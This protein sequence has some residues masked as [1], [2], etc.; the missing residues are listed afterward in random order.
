MRRSVCEQ[1]LFVGIASGN[2][3]FPT[4]K[5]AGFSR[6]VEVYS[7]FGFCNLTT[8]QAFGVDPRQSHRRPVFATTYLWLTGYSL[9]QRFTAGRA[10]HITITI[11]RL[12]STHFSSPLEVELE[13]ERRTSEAE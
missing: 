2:G 9:P 13:E 5:R 6:V 1:A 12:S 8:G 3:R 7:V 11:V 10:V 4:L